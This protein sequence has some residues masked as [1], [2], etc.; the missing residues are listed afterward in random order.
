VG[1]TFHEGLLALQTFMSIIAATVLVLAAVVA[2]RKRAVRR[3]MAHD[4]TTRLLAAA[5]S[6]REAIPQALRTICEQLDWDMGALWHVDR[7]AQVLRCEQSWMRPASDLAEF[8]AISRAQTFAPGV[9]LPGRVWESRTPAWMVDVS[10][11]GHCPRTPIAAKAG[12]HAGFAFPIRLGNDIIGVMEFF[13]RERRPPDDDLLQMAAALGSQ[14]G[15]FCERTRTEEALREGEERLRVALQAGQMGTWEWNITTG[16]LTWSE[17][18][19]AIHGLAPGTFPGTYQA[20]FSDIH[21]DDRDR[22]TDAIVK[23]LAEGSGHH[24]TY[25]MPRPTH[26]GGGGTSSAH[27]RGMH[28]YHRP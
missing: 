22:V 2:E 27:E 7:E 28:G 19:E 10:M 16:Q 3:L 11:D 25:R 14:F 9:S 26:C 6:P 4:A 13:S 8:A 15:Q 20:Y 18:L 21:P 17:T 23:T 24:L 1:A 12:L 5:I